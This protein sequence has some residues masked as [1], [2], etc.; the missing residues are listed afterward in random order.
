MSAKLPHSAFEFYFG[1]GPGRSYQAVADR[2]VV[3]KRAVT[4][5]AAQERWQDRLA[6]LEEKAR[7]SAEQKA[8]DF[9]VRSSQ[10]REETP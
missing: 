10:K 5:H 1:L 7:L 6:K 2:F 3:T 4:K 8:L 9:P